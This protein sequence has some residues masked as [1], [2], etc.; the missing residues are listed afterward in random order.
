[1]GGLEHPTQLGLVGKPDTSLGHSFLKD[2]FGPLH[3]LA[4]VRAAHR[5]LHS[6][7]NRWARFFRGFAEAEHLLERS[8][9]AMAEDGE[10]LALAVGHPIELDYAPFADERQVAVPG[11]V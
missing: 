7:G 3:H 9:H 10:A 2:M 4:R 8:R 11:M 6:L 1:M 5:E